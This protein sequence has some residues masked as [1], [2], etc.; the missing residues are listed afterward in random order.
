MVFQSNNKKHNYY[1]IIINIYIVWYG[2]LEGGNKQDMK[3]K[4]STSFSFVKIRVQRSSTTWWI[5]EKFFFYNLTYGVEKDGV[6]IWLFFLTFW[7]KRTVSKQWVE[8]WITRLSNIEKDIW[9]PWYY[10]R[11]SEFASVWDP[12]K[13]NRTFDFE[14]LTQKESIN[15]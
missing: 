13:K 5:Y 7:E 8:R 10:T 2:T 3:K 11:E 4:T 9:T 15:K 1:Q 14:V 12:S 6:F